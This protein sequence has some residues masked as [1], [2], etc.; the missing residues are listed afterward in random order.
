MFRDYLLLSLRIDKYGFSASQTRP[1][2]E[3]AEFNFK[4][5]NNLE[6]LPAQQKKELKEGVIKMM[7]TN[8]YPK[9]TIT[10][11]FWSYETNNIYLFSQSSAVIN[12]FVDIFE[13]TFEL[14]LTP[15]SILDGVDQFDSLEGVEPFYTK[16]WKV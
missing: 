9:T 16:I 15:I 11:L 4:R 6:H 13:K 14:N 8:T 1:Y 7:R 2:L 3:E 10:E 5:S 12:K